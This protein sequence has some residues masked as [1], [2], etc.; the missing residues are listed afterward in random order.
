MDRN[1]V[2]EVLTDKYRYLFIN[3]FNKIYD[4]QS[5][6]VDVELHKDEISEFSIDFKIDDTRTNHGDAY[7]IGK[8]LR[9]ASDY[10][11]EFLYKYPVNPK[12][13]KIDT[14]IQDFM[15]NDGLFLEF[16]YALD[17]KHIMLV[18]FRVSYEG[19]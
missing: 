12:T 19:K 4:L 13:A 3:E 7:D 9:D 15:V 16:D 14:T 2:E 5:V 17:E 6:S 1:K 11:S 10:I 8:M 18:T